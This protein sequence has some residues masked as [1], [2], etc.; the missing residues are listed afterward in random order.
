MDDP[1]T[2]RVRLLTAGALSCL[3]L[4]ACSSVTDEGRDSVAPPTPS[5]ILEG[6]VSGLTASPVVLR[7]GDKQ[8]TVAA[9][10]RFSFGAIPAGP[11]SVTVATQPLGKICTVAG[12]SGTASTDVRNVAV[13]CAQDPNAPTFKVGG[14]VVGLAAAAAGLRL[15]LT[16]DAGTEIV[17]VAAGGTSFGFTSE[18]LTDFDYEVTI[19][20][21]PSVPGVGGA[22]ATVHNCA[23]RNASGT[24]TDSD[25]TDVEVSCSFTIGG[26]AIPFAAAINPGLQLRLALP[27]GPPEVLPVSAAGPFTFATRVP[28]TAGA[29]YAIS[30]AAQPAGQTCVLGNAGVVALSTPGNVA[31]ASVTCKDDPGGP[32]SGAPLSG[33]YKLGAGR[34]F[35]SFFTDGTYLLGTHGATATAS[36]I[37]HGFYWYGA[38]GPGTLYLVPI[39]DTDGPASGFSQY[40]KINFFGTDYVPITVITIPANGQLS[41]T[42]SA[43][44]PGAAPFLATAVASGPGLQGAWSS[45]SNRYTVLVYDSSAG[46]NTG[47]YY[48]VDNGLLAFFGTASLPQIEDICL[49]GITDVNATSGSYTQDRAPACM[50]GGLALLDLPDPLVPGFN[51]FQGQPGTPFG[52]PPAVPFAV[53]GGGATLTLSP[54]GPPPT[55]LTRHASNVVTP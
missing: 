40:P 4:I 42:I 55:L 12:G 35:V 1:V 15:L 39:T 14:T 13:G 10:G 45:G 49:A 25:V 7:N 2:R 9:N 38:F 43:G 48:S 11:Y 34:S 37:E 44:T 32:F 33:T 3:G 22:P 30:I 16:S 54:A 36:G 21:S 28:S 6:A 47:V 51:S 46:V 18:L 5:I 41:G 50:P 20:A 52:P 31:N 53:S 8:I 29:N 23:L 17:P 24:I 27:S 26:A 19:E